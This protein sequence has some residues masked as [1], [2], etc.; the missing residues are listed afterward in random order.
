VATFD[1]IVFL[2]QM[3]KPCLAEVSMNVHGTR[4]V[5][6]LVEVLSKDTKKSEQVLLSII[7]YLRP[8]IK[9]LSLVS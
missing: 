7:D 4:A 3:I 6:T 9:E 8:Q 1:E 2:S 5:Q